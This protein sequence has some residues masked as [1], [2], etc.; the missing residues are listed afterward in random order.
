MVVVLQVG[1][2]CAGP[3]D[4]IG[5]IASLRCI[6]HRDAGPGLFGQLDREA[7]DRGEECRSLEASPGARGATRDGGGLWIEGDVAECPDSCERTD[8][9]A[10]ARTRSDDDDTEA[11]IGHLGQALRMVMGVQRGRGVTAD[12]ENRHVAPTEP[13]VLTTGTGGPATQI[14]HGEAAPRLPFHDLHDVAM[15]LPRMAGWPGHEH[16]ESTRQ[17]LQVGPHRCGAT[18]PAPGGRQG[19]PAEGGREAESARQV[20]PGR[21]GFDDDQRTSLGPR[22]GHEAGKGRD[23]GSTFQREHADERHRFPPVAVAAV[24]AAGSSTRLT[25]SAEEAVATTGATEDATSI[26]T[27]S[28]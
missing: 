26:D 28:A 23:A 4:D 6:G 18:A 14:D 1:R 20:A 8:L 10:V 5:T 7:A 9:G 12:H 16:G 27:S 22:R 17:V 15:R 13:V 11:T 25:W 2:A 21:I 3:F 24:T 19:R